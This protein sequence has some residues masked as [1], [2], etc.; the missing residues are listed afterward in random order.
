M[1]KK[2]GLWSVITQELYQNFNKTSKRKRNVMSRVVNIK[3]HFDPQNEREEYELNRLGETSTDAAETLRDYLVNEIIASIKDQ[4]D[5]VHF[6]FS[7]VGGYSIPIFV[8][9]SFK[10]LEEALRDA[11]EHVDIELKNRIENVIHNGLVPYVSITALNK[12]AAGL[13]LGSIDAGS[14]VTT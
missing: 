8:E 5:G 10:K 13:I 12:P 9:T 3:N 2:Q 14:I 1:A 7:N 6:D 11:A 4:E